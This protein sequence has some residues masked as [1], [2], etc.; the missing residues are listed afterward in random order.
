MDFQKAVARGNSLLTAMNDSVQDTAQSE[1]TSYADLAR[2]GWEVE[3]DYG[4]MNPQPEREI[5]MITSHPTLVVTHP[6]GSM[7]EYRWPHHEQTVH[8]FIVYH[9]TGGWY[10]QS[11][12][13]PGGSIF[14]TSLSS[15]A[16]Q[17]PKEH[18]PVTGSPNRLPLLQH[19]SDV[20][21]LQWAELAEND[22]QRRGLQRVVHCEITNEDTRAVIDEIMAKRKLTIEDINP[23]PGMIV[24]PSDG[25]GN[26]SKALL[27]TPNACGTA[28][29][30]AQHKAAHQLG[31]KT[32]KS[33]SVFSAGQAPA[34]GRHHQ[35]EG[36]RGYA[37]V[38]NIG[39]LQVVIRMAREGR[40]AL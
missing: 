36:R 18:P 20:T 39:D 34:K 19:W 8:N 1:W 4:V 22:E 6:A 9:G 12:S 7:E 27:G 40:R 32:V 10:A 5:D 26:D 37:L 14:A 21:Y 29:L 11:Y 35:H 2:F 31:R 3:Y 15:P 33:I 38:I 16:N 28:Y 23:Y 13:L 17:G 30:L 25:D 24:L